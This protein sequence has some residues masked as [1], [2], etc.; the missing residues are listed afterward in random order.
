MSATSSAS[1]ACVVDVSSSANSL[2][3]L[4][5]FGSTKVQVKKGRR[6]NSFLHDS[7]FEAGLQIGVKDM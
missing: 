2:G 4:Q 5:E 3:L 1:E 7:A 6:P